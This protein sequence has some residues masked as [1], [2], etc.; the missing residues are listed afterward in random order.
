MKTK[1]ELEFLTKETLLK[2][3]ENS[4]DSRLFQSVIFAKRQEPID[5][6]EAGNLSC[7]YFV[8]GLLTLVG[9][10]DKP[11]VTVRGLLKNLESNSKFEKLTSTHYLPGDILIWDQTIESNGH[12][13]VGFYLG[14]GEAVS[15]SPSEL[16][17]IKHHYT[18]NGKRNIVAAFR[19][20]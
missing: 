3:I 13:H 5:I 6:L 20:H 17:I 10:I 9:L 2:L 16:Q 1:A 11:H 4:I 18:Y 12:E 15:N 7:S 14:N 19:L 8:S